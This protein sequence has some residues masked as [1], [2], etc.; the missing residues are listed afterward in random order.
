MH[1]PH[2]E[3]SSNRHSSCKHIRTCCT[4]VTTRELVLARAKNRSYWRGLRVLFRVLMDNGQEVKPQEVFFI[5][6]ICIIILLSG[7]LGL[8]SLLTHCLYCGYFLMSLRHPFI[9]KPLLL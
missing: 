5:G 2:E 1:R 6:C 7:S 8:K 3:W 4:H 9:N